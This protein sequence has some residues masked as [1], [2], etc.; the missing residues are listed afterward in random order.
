MHDPRAEHELE[1]PLAVGRV[2]FLGSPRNGR[3]YGVYLGVL[4]GICFA[5]AIGYIVRDARSL[6]S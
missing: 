3:L 6:G 5:M 2:E 1:T 4:I